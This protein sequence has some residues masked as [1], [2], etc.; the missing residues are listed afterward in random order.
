MAAHLV[1]TPRGDDSFLRM[2][3]VGGGGTP[4]PAAGG[5]AGGPLVR[6]GILRRRVIDSFLT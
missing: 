4:P 6:L 1:H 5:D 3:R 2:D